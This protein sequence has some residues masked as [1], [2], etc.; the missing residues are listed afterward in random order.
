V[1]TTKESKNLSRHQNP[2]KDPFHHPGKDPFH[3]PGKDP[4][5]HPGKD[6]FH[7]PGKDPFHHPGKDP[8]HDPGK[9]AFHRVPDQK[10]KAMYGTRWNSSLP[11]E[12][13]STKTNNQ[14]TH[15]KHI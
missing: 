10:L 4:F 6:P 13:L 9:D 8:F 15:T 2:G 14:K 5:H 1:R 3:H 11:P 12:F 7:H